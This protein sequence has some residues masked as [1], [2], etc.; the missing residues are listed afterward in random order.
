MLNARN[1]LAPKD[2]DA[3]WAEGYKLSTGETIN[4]AQRGRVQLAQEAARHT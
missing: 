4:Y 3:A 1:S 2:F